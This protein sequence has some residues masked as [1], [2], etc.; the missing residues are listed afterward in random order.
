[1]VCIAAVP[2]SNISIKQRHTLLLFIA[3]FAP[4]RPISK[5]TLQTTVFTIGF[6][7]ILLGLE[8]NE[9]EK[10]VRVARNQA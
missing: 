4:L 2:K 1:V 3:I 9:K 8:K 5:S 10:K 6:Q 7:I